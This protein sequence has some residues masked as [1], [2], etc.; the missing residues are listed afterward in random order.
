[1]SACLSLGDSD[2]ESNQKFFPAIFFFVLYV[3]W[4]ESGGHA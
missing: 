4:D 2:S 3:L 1:M